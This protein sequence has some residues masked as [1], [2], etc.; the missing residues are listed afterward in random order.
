MKNTLYFLLLFIVSCSENETTIE[1]NEVLSYSDSVIIES[2]KIQDSAFGCL[3][4][5]DEVTEKKVIDVVNRVNSINAELNKL[6]AT[7]TKE[8]VREIV[9]HDTVYITEKKNFWGKTKIKIDSSK[10]TTEK[11]DTIINE[12]N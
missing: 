7:I 4:T 8:V 5:A 11:I 6:K 3:K 9:I 10:S 2:K 12:E 1:K